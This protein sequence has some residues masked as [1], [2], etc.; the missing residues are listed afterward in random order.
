M[1]QNRVVL[2][3]TDGI[4]SKPAGPYNA[5]DNADKPTYRHLFK[6]VPNS[7]IKTHGPAVG[8]PEG[9]MGNSEVGHMTIGSGRIIYQDL[10]RISHAVIDGTLEK[11]TLFLEMKQGSG[12]FHII[13]LCS[14]GGVHSH[15]N[16]ITGIAKLLGQ[17]GRKVFLHLI[18]DG[19]DVSPVSSPGYLRLIEAVTDDTISIAT[20]GGRFYTMDRDKRWERVK[21]GYDAMVDGASPT[22]MSP[23]EYIASQ[24]AKEITDEFLEPAGFYGYKGMEPGD[25]VLLANFRSDR[26]RQ[27]TELLSDPDFMPIDVTKKALRI[28]TMTEYSKEFDLPILF[29]K[30]TPK[31]TLA[32]VVSRAGLTQFHTAETEKYAHVT[33]FLNGGIEEPFENET[34]VIPSPRVGTYDEKPEMSAPEVCDAVLKAM[35]AHYD[36]VIV[37]FANGDMVGHTGNYEAALTAVETVDAALGKIVASCD[38]NGYAMVLTSD[39]GNCE[40]MRAPDGSMLTNHTVG[41]VFC[42]V[43]AKGVHSVKNGGLSNIAPTVLTLMNQPVPSEMDAPLI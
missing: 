37:N 38:K 5:F 13:G 36:L 19:R 25:N 1:K 18:T 11:N 24:Y 39:H 34:R 12:S 35:D 27:I 33:F 8:L 4:G 17:T 15:I 22:D 21:R 20:I 40:E 42:F 16:H 29:T 6:K 32:E 30:A 31:N 41:D 14:D 10:E 23:Q 43:R 9:Q 28:V 2:V 26:V 3:I 7:L